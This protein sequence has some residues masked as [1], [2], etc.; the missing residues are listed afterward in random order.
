MTDRL[1]MLRD[2]LQ[3]DLNLTIDDLAPASEDASFRKYFRI[4]SGQLTYIVMDAPPEK[5]SCDAFLDVSERL[6]HC[7]TNAPEVYAKDL[8]KG[9][10]L[11]SDLGTELYLDKL[12]EDNADQLYGDAITA[13]LKMQ[14]RASVE[15]LP[16]YSE[17]LLMQEMTLFRDWLLD[18][19]L[20]SP[21][22]G[23]SLKQMEDLFI[24]LIKSAKSQ[25]QIFVHRDYHSRNLILNRNNP[26]IIDYQD[27][28]LGPLSYDL[29]SL[30]KD[31]YIKWP[32]SRVQFWIGDYYQQLVSN[33]D[34]Q[35]SAENFKRCFDLMGVQRHLKASG[36]FA[37]L[38]HRDHKPAYLQDI[39]RTLSYI[40]DLEGVYPELEH[41]IDLLKNS[42]LPAMQD[43]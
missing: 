35:L 19:H 23:K 5:E 29:V 3:L 34:V 14:F 22:T 33:Y 32:Q 17:K 38:N 31:C 8:E 9:F 6:R 12:N 37:R 26:G 21:L 30:L 16:V 24:L 7:G 36:I 10:L 11:L 1:Q 42:V 13:L 40:V 28:V 41:L 27:A 18:K 20:G 2:W 15:K 25:P 4:I 43:L 39:P